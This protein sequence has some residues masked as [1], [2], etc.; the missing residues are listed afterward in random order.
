MALRPVHWHEGMFIRPHHFQAAHTYMTSLVARSEKWNSHYNWGLRSIELDE[1][2]L[3]NSRLVIRSLRARLHD[4]TPV[5]IPEDATLLERNL[6]P[7]FERESSV[8]ALLGLPAMHSGRPNVSKSDT[9]GHR[10]L[11]ETNAIEDENTGQNPQDID[12]RL[13]N[14]R[15][16]LST[17][18]VQGYETLPIA[19]IIKSAAAEGA[20]ELDLSYIPPVLSTDAWKPLNTEVLHKVFDRVGRKLSLL[21]DQI[22]N[23]GITF[24]SQAQG[25][26]KTFEQVRVLNEASALFNTLFFAEGVHPFNAY[27][28]LCRLVGQLAILGAQRRPPDLPRYDHDDLG[29]CYYTALRHIDDLLNIIEEPIYKERPFIG[30][31]LRMQVALETSW[32]EPQWLMFVGMRSPLPAEEAQRLMTKDPRS[33]H[34]LDMKIGSSERA[35]EIFKLGL[36]GLRFNYNPKPPR[37]LPSIPG[38]IYFEVDRAS[39]KEEWAR[40]QQ[41]LTLAI[42]MNERL[43]DGNIQGQKRLTIRT[44]GQNTWIELTLF[45]MPQEPKTQS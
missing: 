10:Y 3:A 8:V 25:D 7:V 16:L 9:D 23:R 45:V 39:Q 15:L 2:A 40:V 5:S 24:D 11:I 27:A 41:T 32:L 29:K 19:R 21:A 34:G 28:E 38:L 31:G 12:I 26:R 22:V 1:T 35:D 14:L 4:G 36:P 44:S 43:I 6:K 17:D 37:A 18:D 20:P 30:S 33:G 13:L 42:R